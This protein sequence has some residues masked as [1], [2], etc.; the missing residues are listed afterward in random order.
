[1]PAD[2]VVTR[3]RRVWPNSI[4][5]SQSSDD[6]VGV[7]PFEELGSELPLL[8]E[9]LVEDSVDVEPDSDVEVEVVDDD[10]DALSEGRASFR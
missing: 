6:E 1:M 5:A 7:L 8:S 2:P 3:G 10:F 4:S 9:E